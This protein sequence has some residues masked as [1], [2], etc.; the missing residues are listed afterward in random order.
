MR[1]RPGESMQT[2]LSVWQLSRSDECRPL[3]TREPRNLT[4]FTFLKGNEDG[5]WY[6]GVTVT[7]DKLGDASDGDVVVRSRQ[8]IRKDALFPTLGFTAEHFRDFRKRSWWKDTFF[9]ID[10]ITTVPLWGLGLWS[11]GRLS[12]GGNLFAA[13]DGFRSINDILV[14]DEMLVHLEE[15]T[16]PQEYKF[17]QPQVSRPSWI[18]IVGDWYHPVSSTADGKFKDWTV[19]QDGF[20]HNQLRLDAKTG[21]V[22][23]KRDLKKNE[24]F[25]LFPDELVST[26]SGESFYF[27]GDAQAQKAYLIP[28]LGLGIGSFIQK[29]KDGGNISI[30]E[31]VVT[32]LQDIRKDVEVYFN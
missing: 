11:S 1:Q 29:A 5:F 15:E 14:G 3:N 32:V 13:S 17:D 31:D 21:K 2:V 9:F 8:K 22:V 28:L 16:K 23:A 12:E 25:S 7:R 18:Q 20:V 19:T 10:D 30:R 6:S 27:V 26:N 4:D 24:T